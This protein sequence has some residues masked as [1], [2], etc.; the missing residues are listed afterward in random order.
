MS[1]FWNPCL[2]QLSIVVSSLYW[3]LFFILPRLPTIAQNEQT[4]ESSSLVIPMHIDLAL[5]LVPVL[6]LLA[7]FIFLEEK[8]SE[9]EVRYGVPIVTVL[10]TIW[11]GSWAEYCGSFNG[12]REESNTTRCFFSSLTI[13]FYFQ[14]LTH[15][16]RTTLSRFVLPPIP[17]LRHL[18]WCPSGSLTLCT[19]TSPLLQGSSSHNDGGVHL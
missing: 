9:S 4:T 1:T 8:L 6:A 12:S 13:S 18:L 14:F 3:T 5:H 7:D 16:L 11:Y 15:S 19:P 10:F 17:V 2:H